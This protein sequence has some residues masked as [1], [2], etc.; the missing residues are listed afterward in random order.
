MLHQSLIPESI[1][2]VQELNRIFLRSLQTTA[3][4]DRACHSLPQRIAN[5]LR[6]APPSV[7]Q[8]VACVPRAL[9]KINLAR[10]TDPIQITDQPDEL[11]EHA[12]L[13]LNL[14]VLFAAWNSARQ[15]DYQAQLLFGLQPGAIHRLRTLG[16]SEL[17]NLALSPGLL[18]C[19]FATSGVLWEW[20][21]KLS[22]MEI[23][24]ELT[25]I[26]LQPIADSEAP[27]R[28]VSAGAPYRVSQ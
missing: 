7:L 22:S 10:D 18:T 2:L 19:A 11:L 9:F 6:R 5:G 17:H 3:L 21:L 13:A 25:L 27:M 20:L 8:A 4:K 28:V 16:V 15:S 1:E 23:P 26:A 12:R 14:T 24:R